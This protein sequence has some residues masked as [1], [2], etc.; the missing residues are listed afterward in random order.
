MY[1][2][3]SCYCLEVVSLSLSLSTLLDIKRSLKDT[4]F[5]VLL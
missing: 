3:D 2:F 1:I 5:M 4:F